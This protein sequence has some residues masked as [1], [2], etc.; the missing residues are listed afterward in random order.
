MQEE[1]KRNKDSPRPTQLLCK[2]KLHKNQEMKNTETP[3]CYGTR[4]EDIEEN[5]EKGTDSPRP[6]QLLW[7]R[8]R[9]SYQKKKTQTHPGLMEERRK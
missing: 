6:T 9:K 1:R 5:E 3:K 8:K 7:K 2:K 4:E